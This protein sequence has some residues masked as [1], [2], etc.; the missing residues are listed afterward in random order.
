[1]GNKFQG[2]FYGARFLAFYHISHR[3]V[4]WFTESQILQTVLAALRDHGECGKLPRVTHSHGV[5]NTTVTVS[6]MYRF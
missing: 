5:Q 3:L 2:G 6:A 1:M 4:V